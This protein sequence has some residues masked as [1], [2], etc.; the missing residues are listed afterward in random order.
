M[1]DVV[2]MTRDDV[3]N[4]PSFGEKSLDEVAEVI[5]L[6]G[7]R[8][9]MPLERDENGTLWALEDDEGASEGSNEA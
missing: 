8:F 1:F 7:L 6:N 4:V 9:A 2:I 3:L 5:A